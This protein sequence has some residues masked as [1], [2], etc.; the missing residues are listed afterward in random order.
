ME[1]VHFSVSIRTRK[2]IIAASITITH[3]IKKFLNT[4]KESAENSRIVII[5]MLT[6]QEKS[7]IELLIQDFRIISIIGAAKLFSKDTPHIITEA[8]HPW[9]HSLYNND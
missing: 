3:Y 5:V 2:K 4:H 7:S 8:A 6:R 9:S 1:I